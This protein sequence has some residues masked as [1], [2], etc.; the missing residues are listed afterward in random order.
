[1]NFVKSSISGPY[2]IWA[3]HLVAMTENNEES[4]FLLDD[5]GCPTNLNVFPALQKIVTNTTRQLRANFQSFKFASSSVL[6][7]SVL[8]QFCPKQCPPVRK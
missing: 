4:I 7:F 6:R 5:H 2:D 3:S 1:M 8:V